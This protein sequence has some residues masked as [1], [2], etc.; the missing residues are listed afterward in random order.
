MSNAERILVRGELSGWVHAGRV[1]AALT[2]VI[3]VVLAVAVAPWGWIVASAGGALCLLLEWMAWQARRVRTWLTLHPDGMEIETRDGYRAIHDSQVSAI[4]L[5]TKKNL[6]NGELTSITRK[7]TVWTEDGQPLLMQNKIKLG[8]TDPLAWL[9]ERLLARLQRRME[10]DVERGGTASGDGWHLS[11]S[12]LTLGQPPNDDQIPLSEI[13]AVEPSEGRMCVWKRGSDLAVA[14]LPLSGKNVHLLPA[15]ARPFLPELVERNAAAESVSELGRV[16]FERRAQR[17]T[18]LAAAIASVA[19][20]IGGAALMGAFMG[21]PNMDEGFMVGGLA[22]LSIGI[23][24]GL[25]GLWLAY[26]SF[27]CHERGVWKGTLFSKNTLRYVDVGSFQFSAVRQYHHGA[28]IGTQ[29]TMR[30]RPIA[31]DRGPTIRYSTRTQGDNDDL[32]RLRD[33]ISRIIAGR[34]LEEF[35]AGRPVTWTANLEYRAEG[36]RYRPGGFLGRKAPQ[37]LPYDEYGGHE[38]KQGSFHLYARG[39]KKPIMAEQT[40]AENFY[41]GFTLLLMLVHEPVSKLAAG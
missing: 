24:V 31:A 5:E 26:A 25:L 23:V 30:F 32:D 15:V 22:L 33:S 12:V 4:A 16:L 7:F 6:V 19:A 21:R 38:L 34:M 37:L 17:N 10:E 29:L 8:R 18:L 35:R 9:I 14:K 2:A 11:R 13:T 1:L 40:S 39:R 27:R 36:I 28:Y 20:A 3:G 41:P